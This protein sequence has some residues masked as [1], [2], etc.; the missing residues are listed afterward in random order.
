M[1]CSWVFFRT[2]DI[3]YTVSLDRAGKGQL[4]WIAETYLARAGA[5]DGGSNCSN[6]VILEKK[7]NSRTFGRVITQRREGGREGGNEVENG[8]LQ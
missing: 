8:H 1:H 5:V 2:H 4:A 6:D 7:E 3:G